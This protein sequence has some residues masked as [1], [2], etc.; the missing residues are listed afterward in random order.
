MSELGPGIRTAG[1]VPRVKRVSELGPGIRTAI[2]VVTLFRADAF[3]FPERCMILVGSESY[4]LDPAVARALSPRQGDAFVVIPMV[5]PHTSLNVADAL[6]METILSI[7][8]PVFCRPTAWAS[9]RCMR[10]GR[11]PPRRT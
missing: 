8:W 7:P 9:P 10:T 5:G 2:S 11:A 1:N 3:K 4:G 6:G